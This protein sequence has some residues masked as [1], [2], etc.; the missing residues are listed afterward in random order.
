MRKSRIKPY[1]TPDEPQGLNALQ[2]RRRRR[3]DLIEIANYAALLGLW[4]LAAVFLID[5]AKVAW[6]W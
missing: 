4:I 1:G 5:W 6:P 2:P 3:H